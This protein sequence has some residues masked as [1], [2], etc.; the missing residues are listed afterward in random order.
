MKIAQDEIG[1]YAKNIKTV[2]CIRD[3]QLSVYRFITFVQTLN[4]VE[5]GY[6]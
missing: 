3:C 2:L 5:N 4:T 6:H 1:L